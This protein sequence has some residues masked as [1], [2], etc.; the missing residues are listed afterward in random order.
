MKILKGTSVSSGL[1]KGIVCLYSN[2]EEGTVPHYTIS[3]EQISNEIARLKESL[4]KAKNIMQDIIRLSEKLSDKRATEIF[5]AHMMILN[6]HGLFEK[7]SNLIKEK[8][9][10]A[11]HAVNDVFEEY[12]NLYETKQMHFKEL[13]HDFMDLKERVLTSF[14][15]L[16]GHFECPIG[17]RQPV[18]VASQ[19]LTPYMVL[20]ILKQNVLAFITEE[21]GYTTHAM[22]LAR[23]MGVPVIYDINV[24]ENLKCADRVIVDGFSGKV[25][26]S[27]DKNTEEYYSE[28]IERFNK[29]KMFCDIRKGLPP[30]TKS[31]IRVKLK[32]NISTP[33]ELDIIK[34][35]H[36]DGIGLLRTEFLFL[37]RD[38]PPSEQEQFDMYKLI[39]EKVEDKPVIV[40]LLDIGSDK[41]PLFLELPN[42][43][44]PDLEIKGARAV[45]KF[46]GV[47]LTQ[48]KAVLRAARFGDLRVLYPMI[49]DISDIFTFKKLISDAQKVLREE[50]KEFIK[51]ITD[52]VMIETPS[53]AIMADMLLRN[54]S[55]ANIG[56][57]DLLQY[58]LAASRGN[59]IVEKRYHILHP[60]LIRLFEII[61]KAGKIHKKEI[62][63]CGEVGSFEEFYPL[64]LKLGLRS[65]SV[66]ASK[67]PYI[68]CELLHMR[69]S[70]K[71]NILKKVYSAE[72]KSDLDRLF[73]RKIL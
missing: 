15:G 72:S 9:I 68:K 70:R 4:E 67:F 69:I 7:I 20:N 22:I 62:C 33:G 71:L 27:P 59:P 48:A 47:Y 21:G 2:E 37:E 28:K 57:N 31:N 12:I 46:Y 53:A 50:K 32:L 35:F 5:N 64:F 66:A 55:F 1:V 54:V 39:L 40:R 6:D 63:L 14:S 18:V 42:Q 58:T 60:S 17:E 26:V 10:N 52:G 51:K 65:F 41:L 56:S 24:K 11:E 16:S 25:I 13:A 29:R 30:K 34:E 44:N 45:E 3:D 61:V 73:K 43:I 38:H 23:S 36:H 19:R 49:S 8:K